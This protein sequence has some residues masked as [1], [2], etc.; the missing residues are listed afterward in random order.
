MVLREFQLLIKP[1]SADCNAACRYCF[2]TRVADEG[3]YPDTPVH[4]MPM[5]VLER[6][7]HDLLSY[8]FR[9][10]VFSWQGGEPTMMGLDF[11]KE[12]VRLQEKY[13]LAEQVIGNALQTNGILIDAGWAEFLA[14]YRF[15]V[16]LSLDGPREIHDTYRCKRGGGS[17]W[18]D[19]MRAVELCRQHRVSFN[20][21]SV[22]SAANQYGAREVYRWL[23]NQGFDYLQFIPCIELEPDGGEIAPFSTSPEGYGDFLCELFDEWYDSGDYRTISVRMFDSVLNY[24]VTGRSGMCILDPT[25][26]V[27]LVVEHNGDIYPC[28]FFVRPD[29]YLGNLMDQ[30]LE[31][32]FDGGIHQCFAGSKVGDVH[33]ECTAC[34]WWAMCHAG[35]QKNRVAAG[36]IEPKRT[37]FCQSYK[38]FFAHTRSRFE[39]LRDDVRRQR[40][41]VAVPAGAK[42]GRNDPC[43]CGSGKKFKQCCMNAH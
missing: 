13:A 39:L 9:N 30:P 38:R 5:D 43:P 6:M 1:A 10:T 15:L 19:V 33:P 40:A 37:Y 23:V 31:T 24:Y 32:F 3:M 22:V 35:C 12:A 26:D 42:V 7:T 17:Y 34:Q 28:D 20:I 18:D 4:R 2:Y 21:L 8:R 27:Y 29:M 36:D 41:A 11:F 16:G 25:C 14:R